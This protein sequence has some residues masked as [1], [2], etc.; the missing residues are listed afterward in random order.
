MLLLHKS[1][2]KYYIHKF[3]E[4][5]NYLRPD[6]DAAFS[7]VGRALDLLKEWR[8]AAPFDAIEPIYWTAIASLFLRRPP[9]TTELENILNPVHT[10]LLAKRTDSLRKSGDEIPTTPVTFR[11]PN[12]SS[13]KK[14][15]C[16]RTLIELSAEVWDPVLIAEPKEWTRIRVSSSTSGVLD[17]NLSDSYFDP[18][19]AMLFCASV[20]FHP[21]EFVRD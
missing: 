5:F 21:E 12:E 20:Y 19:T 8:L 2:A 17:L 4:A 11:E 13:V 1:N 10:V 15:E 3:L 16:L 14:V 18:D 7:H 6:Y 9:K